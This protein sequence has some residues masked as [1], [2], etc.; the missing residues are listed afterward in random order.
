MQFAFPRFSTARTTETNAISANP[1][2]LMN[3]KK[4]EVK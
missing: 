2:A 1:S 4:K 3:N